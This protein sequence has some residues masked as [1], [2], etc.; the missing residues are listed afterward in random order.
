[1]ATVNEAKTVVIPETV[2]VLKQL[3]FNFTK[4]KSLVKEERKGVFSIR[5]FSTTMA[6][7]GSYSDYTQHCTELTEQETPAL[8][9]DSVT[10]EDGTVI[11]G[12]MYAEATGKFIDKVWSK[13]YKYIAPVQDDYEIDIED[14]VE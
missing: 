9:A 1:M 13:T 6:E 11:T 4:F 7:D 8:L 14:I 12:A 2:N 5:A 3:I 10:L